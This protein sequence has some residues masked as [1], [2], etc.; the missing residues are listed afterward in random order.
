MKINNF[1]DVLNIAKERAGKLVNEDQINNVILAALKP[2]VS[3]NEQEEYSLD[4]E[5]VPAWCLKN[6]CGSYFFVLREFKSKEAICP[7]CNG[8]HKVRCFKNGR[9][10]VY[11]I[12]EKKAK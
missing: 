3:L 9:I 7:S 10:D 11:N 1:E 12:E 6:G 5:I 8:K 4:K 2:F